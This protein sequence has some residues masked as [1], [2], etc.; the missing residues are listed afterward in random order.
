MKWILTLLLFLFTFSFTFSQESVKQESFK[1]FTIVIRDM[2][3]EIDSLKMKSL[4]DSLQLMINANKENKNQI[5]KLKVDTAK[6]CQEVKTLK[7]QI[8]FLNETKVKFEKDSLQIVEYEKNILQK[9]IRIDEEKKLGEQKLIR[10]IEIG[11]QDILNQIIQMYNR[12]FDELI[13]SSTLKSI[14]RDL[15]I[16]VNNPEITEKLSH[17]QNYFISEKVLFEK[18]NEPR[19][20]ASQSQLSMLVQ[21]ELVRNLVYKLSRYE[22]HNNGLIYTIKQIINI[23][24][25]FTANDDYSQKMKLQ[26]ILSELAY[27]FRNYS[28]NFTDYPYLAE[29]VLEIIK[30]KQKDPNEPISPLLDK[31]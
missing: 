25:T 17:L 13:L 10:G 12:Q 6:L 26:T 31:L 2:Q 16:F 27:Y 30:I 29:R 23:D 1:E 3:K 14:E 4:K 19:V 7:S 18:Y 21:T 15:A 11:K 5:E 20:R 22:L 8:V 9:E 24:S 28:F